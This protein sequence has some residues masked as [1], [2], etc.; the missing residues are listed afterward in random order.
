LCL[1]IAIPIFQPAAPPVDTILLEDVLTLVDSK[2][3][4]IKID[5]EGMECK[6]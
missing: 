4:V 5:I 3:A 6:V 2:V 1:A